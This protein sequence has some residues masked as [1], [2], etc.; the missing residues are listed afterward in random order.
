VNLFEAIK[1]RVRSARRRIL[2]AETKDER[3]LRAA[4]QIQKEGFCRIVLLGEQTQLAEPLARA[5][6]DP[7]RFEFLPPGDPER[8]D[9][10]AR[11]FHELRK[12]KGLT[13]DEARKTVADPVF[14]GAMCV[15]TGE[16]DGMVAGSASPTPHIVRAALYCVGMRE[17]VKTAS[18]C[19]I[20]VFPRTEFGMNG[21]LMFADCGVVPDPTADQL[22]DIT[23]ITADSWRL[24]TGTEPVIALLSFSTKGSAK[25]PGPKKMV[26]V[27]ERLHQLEPDL[28]V[29]GELQADAALV[30]DVARRKCPDSRVG[31][32]ANVIIF[33]NLESGNIGYKLAERLGGG[34]A[35]GP[36]L[37]GLAKPVNDLS[38]GC[39]VQ[40]IVDV[41]AITA[42]Q[43]LAEA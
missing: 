35:V 39:D 15:R 27:A 20:T 11:T 29:D 31:G 32:R 23:R 5:G 22:V 42:V 36:I 40:T 6:G 17:G 41:A 10:F 12:H 21:V 4:G 16:V 9:A 28:V 24:F 38:R 2:L 1:N 3:I 26:E 7:G 43:T 37:Q 33:P 25:A 19:F 18:S 30:P 14:Y 8:L 13:P 34:E